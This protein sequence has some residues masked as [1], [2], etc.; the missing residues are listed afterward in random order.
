MIKFWIELPVAPARAEVADIA[1]SL[2]VLLGGR[3]VWRL[4]QFLAGIAAAGRTLRPL[5]P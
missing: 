2:P 4:S 1:A 5:V 3:I